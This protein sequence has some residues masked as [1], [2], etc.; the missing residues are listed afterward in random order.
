M[1]DIKNNG[2]TKVAFLLSC[3]SVAAPTVAE[4]NAGEPLETFLLGGIGLETSTDSADTT[5]L[6]STVDTSRAG[7][8][9]MDGESM[10][11]DQG[12]GEVPFTTFADHQAGFLVVRRQVARATVWA[13]SDKVEVYTVEAGLRKRQASTANEVLK[14]ACK[15][16][17]SAAPSMDAVVAA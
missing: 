16:R 14:F 7:R 1:T 15:L 2:K 3:A 5:S 12:R 17:H 11:K 8:K 4:L 10:F 6:A 13:A 9:S